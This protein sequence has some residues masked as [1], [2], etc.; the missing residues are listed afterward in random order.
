M[1]TGM[2]R[3]STSGMR[4]GHQM[5]LLF[6][7]AVM[8]P[9][10]VGAA[11]ARA[12]DECF[13]DADCEDNPGDCRVWRCDILPFGDNKCRVDQ[14]DSNAL[15]DDGV[16]CVGLAVDGREVCAAKACVGGSNPG[17][18]CENNFQ[19]D[20][21]ECEPS[22]GAAVCIDDYVPDAPCPEPDYVCDELVD[23]CIYSE[24]NF[25]SDCDDADDC[26]GVETCDT[27]N[28]LCVD[29]TPV[30]CSHLT[31]ECNTGMCN[32]SGG[33]CFASP[34]GDGVP[35]NDFDTCTLQSECQ[36]GVCVGAPPDGCV[37]LRVERTD[38][39]PVSIG[40]VFSVIVYAQANGC[41]SQS[42]EPCAPG[43][44]ALRTIE[45]VFEW[46]PNVL[47]LAD[48]ADIGDHNPERFCGC[49]FDGET[50]FGADVCDIY[51][52]DTFHHVYDWN[53][54]SFPDDCICDGGANSGERCNTDDDCEGGLCDNRVNGPCTL[55]GVND[56]PVNDG[57][58]FFTVG[59][60]LEGC[61]GEDVEPACATAAD[62]G[63]RVGGLKFRVI[64]PAPTGSTNIQLSECA[65]G[66]GTRVVSSI[67]AGLDVMAPITDPGVVVEVSACD[68]PTAVAEGPRYIAV[69]PAEGPLNVAIRVTGTHPDVDCV[70]GYAQADGRVLEAGA[71]G[72]PEDFAVFRPPGPGGWDTVHVRG[73]GLI[74]AQNN[75]DPRTYDVQ[76]D[77]DPANPGTNLS[78]PVSVSL[79]RFG[80]VGGVVGPDGAVD[81]IDITMV[82]DGFRNVWGTPVCCSD[83]GPCG[84][85]GPL[86]FCNTTWEGCASPEVTPGRCQSDYVNLDLRGGFGCVPDKEVDFVDITAAVDSFRSI[87]EP[88]AVVCP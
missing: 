81:F 36:G 74:G 39:S 37:D 43:D 79:P 55:P 34:D 14:D 2:E 78:D 25:D 61:D 73:E 13:V 1:F 51:C 18:V 87:P 3:L 75:V 80:D 7:L 60:A 16:Y 83:D 57:N 38:S 15:C 52:G 66:K 48:P 59:Q 26:N 65:N 10:L 28:N 40:Q 71:G 29:G 41:A 8:A 46:D 32:P 30:D 77:C 58:A 54:F 76:A 4:W 64:G 31:D 72:Q 68:P 84:I 67:G 17:A 44:A 53:S 21:G 11:T 63:L 82:V 24:C 20:G 45:V 49:Y 56:H 85:M 5:R 22:A 88:C 19:C 23:A 27:Q 86:S 62:P 12:Q 35:C 50:C 9:F 70:V 6:L 69:T 42:E 47:E 33:S